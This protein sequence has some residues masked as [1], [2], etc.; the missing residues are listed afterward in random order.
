MRQ[1]RRRRAIVCEPE[2]QVGREGRI[3]LLGPGL[4]FLTYDPTTDQCAYIRKTNSAWK[5]TCR[6]LI[7]K[8]ND[9]SMHIANFQFR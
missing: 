7:V 9:G 8:L 2:E 6:K 5:N 4:R 1:P 3:I